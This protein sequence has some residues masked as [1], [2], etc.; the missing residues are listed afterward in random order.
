MLKVEEYDFH[1]LT[2]IYNL[3]ILWNPFSKYNS[4][5]LRGFFFEQLTYYFIEKM[6]DYEIIREAN[7]HLDNY[8]SHTW[9][10]IVKEDC[11]FFECK[12]YP[13]IH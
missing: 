9:D 7:M 5:E 13:L 12:M 10:I 6:T 4:R 3:F 8:I 1:E 11:S 2:Y